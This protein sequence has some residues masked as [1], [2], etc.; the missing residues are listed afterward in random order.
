[1]DTCKGV[2]SKNGIVIVLPLDLCVFVYF[3]PINV[4]LFCSEVV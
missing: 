4:S 2:G 3:R 1:M